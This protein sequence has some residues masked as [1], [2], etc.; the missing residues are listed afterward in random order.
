MSVRARLIELEQ[1]VSRDTLLTGSALGA[2]DRLD[3]QQTIEILKQRRYLAYAFT[4]M[5]EY[6]LGS[7][8]D[9]NAQTIIAG[10][11]LEEFGLSDGDVVDLGAIVSHRCAFLAELE[12]LNVLPDQAL[13][14]RPSAITMRTLARVAAYVFE[15][16]QKTK[17]EQLVFLRFSGEV[18]TATEFKLLYERL[19][20][21][22]LLNRQKSTFLFPHIDYDMLALDGGTSHAE[23][24]IPLIEGFLES[25]ADWT[26]VEKVLRKAGS[27]RRHF[28][29]QFAL[30]A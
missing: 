17:L 20:R 13:A 19:E 3:E 5:C 9:R 8:R 22:K 1:Q 16:G 30:P 7:V 15:L 23:R 4:P 21:L 26:R 24:Y 28:Y 10:I 12:T 18:L 2:L 29:S 6:F 14:C 27:I 25:K 11:V